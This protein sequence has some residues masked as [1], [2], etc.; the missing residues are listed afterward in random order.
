VPHADQT[1]ADRLAIIDVVNRYGAAIDARDWQRLR[2]CF[3]E[4]AVVNF[5]ERRLEGPEAIARFVEEA[6][7]G[8]RWQQ[9]LLGSHDIAVDGDAATA[10]TQLIATQVS[11]DDPAQALITV[12]AYRDV[13]VRTAAGWRISERT[14]QVGW[15]E[16]RVRQRAG[17]RP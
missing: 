5:G 4:Q 3:A 8:V 13:L 6:T 2:T 14:M 1:T 12:G 10:S 15:R 16:T 17:A 9:H 7:V 11:G